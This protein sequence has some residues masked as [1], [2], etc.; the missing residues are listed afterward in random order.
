[1]AASAVARVSSTAYGHRR[2]HLDRGGLFCEQ[3]IASKPLRTTDASI[4]CFRLVCTDS[5]GG[6]RRLLSGV[7]VGETK[8]ER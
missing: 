6:D 8:P 3:T 4:Q 7:V 2:V 1:M 5:G